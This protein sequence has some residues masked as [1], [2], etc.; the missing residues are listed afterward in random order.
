ML[1]FYGVDLGVRIARKHLGWYIDAASGPA[2]MRARLMR[3]TDPGRVLA[4]LPEALVPQSE[5]A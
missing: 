2:E 5:A 1:A 3:D 4:A